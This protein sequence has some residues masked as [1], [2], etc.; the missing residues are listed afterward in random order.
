MTDYNELI[1]KMAEVYVR[2]VKVYDDYFKE[3]ILGEKKSR[4][5][6]VR[7]Y[8][9]V[10]NDQIA[11]QAIIKSDG[12]LSARQYAGAMEKLLHSGGE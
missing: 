9:A 12:E 8:L 3:P 11:W 4:A 7:D 10:R 6:Q 5:E 2:Q 1:D